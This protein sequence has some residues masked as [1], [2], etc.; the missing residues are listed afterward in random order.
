MA[1]GQTGSGAHLAPTGRDSSQ[2]ER[3]ACALLSTQ[4]SSLLGKHTVTHHEVQGN[5]SN[6]F[7]EY[8]PCGLTYETLFIWC[9]AWTNVL[10]HS[11]AQ[12]LTIAIWDGQQGGKTHLETVADSKEPPEMVQVLSPKSPLQGGSPK[13]DMV[14]DQ[15]KMGEVILYKARTW[16]NTMVARGLGMPECHHGG[17][18]GGDGQGPQNYSRVGVAREQCSGPMRHSAGRCGGHYGCPREHM[19][20]DTARRPHGGPRRYMRLGIARGHHDGCQ[21]HMRLDMAQGHTGD[22]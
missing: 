9:G 4:M 16:W 12:E 5:E 20:L 13:E 21:E 10:E 19:G 7:M 18:R 11:R 2:D 14:A 22:P 1:W 3:G 17:H 6:L 15:S 8:F